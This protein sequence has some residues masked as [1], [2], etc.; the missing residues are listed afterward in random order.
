[1]KPVLQLRRLLRGSSA[2]RQKLQVV[3]A[4]RERLDLKRNTVDHFG[5]EFCVKHADAQPVAI[6]DEKKDVYR[7]VVKPQGFY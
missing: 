7:I 4:A 6:Y 1:M 3:S 5:L 2:E